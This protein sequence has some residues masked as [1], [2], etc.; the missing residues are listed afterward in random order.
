MS[1]TKHSRIINGKKR[2]VYRSQVYVRGTRL[3]SQ[4]F[5][6]KAAAHTWQDEQRR[7]YISG[8]VP[9]AAE[10]QPT[11]KKC[12]EMYLEWA[13]IRLKASSL[14]NYEVRL[15]FIAESF[16]GNV[17]VSEVTSATIDR[18]LDWLKRQPTAKNPGRKSFEREL[19]VLT[20]ILNWYRNYKDASFIVQITKRH[21]EDCRYKPV[22]PRRADYF[23][24]TDEI[25]SWIEWLRKCQ[26][27]VYAELATFMILTGC[28]VSEAAALK[29]DA[30]DVKL[31]LAR[32]VRTVHWDHWT[33]K[34]S[35][36]ETTKTDGSA[37]V[38]LLPDVL[39]AL[40]GE[41]R[42]RNPGSQ[43]VF[44]GRN[45]DLLKYNAIQSRFN[46][47]FKALDLPW[48][49][50]HIC[51]HTYATMALF[52]TRDLTSVQASL[53][54]SRREMTEKYAK[55]VALLSSGTAEQTAKLF[56]LGVEKE[57][58]LTKSLTDFGT[59]EKT[60]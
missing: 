21:R 40:L 57:K 53:G 42:S 32:I 29:W 8:A 2:I 5:D 60:I 43:F 36:Q 39:V 13:K 46:A 1:V 26:S 19:T 10:L 34:P 31:K 35:L 48:R 18:W 54:H 59:I 30:I 41:I 55:A 38:V 15:P 28:R 27:P 25:R 24:R 44:L 14:Q 22:V 50:T 45:G 4:I 3:A 17:K 11:I 6:T 47:G 20:L 58:S 16:L 33:R 23:A 56:D 7:R 12:T 51:R 52:A 37:R 9:V 49:S